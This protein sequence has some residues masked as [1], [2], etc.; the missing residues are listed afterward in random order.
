MVLVGG[1]NI[2]PHILILTRGAT[3]NN[4]HFREALAV[5]LVL[6]CRAQ[7]FGGSGSVAFR[8]SGLTKGVCSPL[9]GVCMSFRVL[10]RPHSIRVRDSVFW[11][12]MQGSDF[13]ECY[14]L[15]TPRGRSIAG[16]LG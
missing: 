4:P 16:V 5:L 10:G 8:V 13:R 6:A 12:K 3:E 2:E 7:D 1:P 14:F 9:S 15:G 11:R